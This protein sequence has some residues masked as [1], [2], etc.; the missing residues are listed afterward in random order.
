[1]VFQEFDQLLPWKTVTSTS[2]SSPSSGMPLSEVSNSTSSRMSN[3]ARQHMYFRRQFTLKEI[4]RGI[5][6]VTSRKAHA[7]SR[8]LFRDCPVALAAVGP[9]K[10]FRLGRKG[11]D[12]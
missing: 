1:M 4:L 2:V 7:L 6:S 5:E 10:Q 9:L 3:L 11:L 12:L 8:E